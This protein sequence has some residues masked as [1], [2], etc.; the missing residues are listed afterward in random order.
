MAEP[1]ANP[2]GTSPGMGPWT[3]KAIATFKIALI[4]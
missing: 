4:T 2:Y 3:I 1:C